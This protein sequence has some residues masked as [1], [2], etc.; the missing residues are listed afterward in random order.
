MIIC[1][2]SDKQFTEQK[3]QGFV[4]FVQE[5]E[6]YKK[7]AEAVGHEVILSE[8]EELAYNEYFEE[9]A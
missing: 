8:K 5:E 9:L 4:L 1:S 2:V 6:S 3:A 7:L